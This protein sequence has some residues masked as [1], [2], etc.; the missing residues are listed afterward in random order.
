M[1][2]ALFEA[3][4]D[5]NT[6][7]MPSEREGL[8]PTYIATR[9]E[10]NEAEQA[11]INE[12]DRWAFS[13]RRGDVLTP[14]FLLQLH[15]RMLGRVWRWAGRLRATERN[16]GIAPYLI[17]TELRRLTD[18]ARFWV[19]HQ[20]FEPDEIAVRFHHRLV[21]IHP[22]ANGNGRHSR[23]AADLLIVQLG[24]RR[25]TWGR[26]NLVTAATTRRQYVQA[27]RA[28]DGHDIRPLLAF[29]RS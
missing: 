21:A 8:I 26:A 24:G 3:D 17:E 11:N 7:L 25:F 4:D 27:L 13:R 15:R 22:F 23:L 12:A 19:D 14:Q 2:D 5:A 6:P 9:A 29:A 16:I 28:A 18:D 20:S 1:T 10:L